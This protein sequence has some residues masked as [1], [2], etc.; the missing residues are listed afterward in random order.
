MQIV[1]KI[2]DGENELF[3]SISEETYEQMALKIESPLD[4]IYKSLKELFGK[5]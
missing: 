4:N 3:T 1:I 5:D 2:I